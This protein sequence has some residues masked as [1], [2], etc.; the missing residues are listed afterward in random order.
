MRTKS[1]QIHKLE[2]IKRAET[3]TKAIMP[4]NLRIAKKKIDRNVTRLKY[5][6]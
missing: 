5:K 6:T 3:E 1:R 4:Q 2:K